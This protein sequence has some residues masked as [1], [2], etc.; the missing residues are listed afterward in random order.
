[1]EEAEAEK[2]L[3]ANLDGAPLAEPNRIR[4]TTGKRKKL[5]NKNCV[6]IGLASGFLE[7][8][9]S[10]SLFMIQSSV[11]RLIRLFPDGAMNPANVK[12]YNRQS[13][14]EYERIRDFIILHYKAT[15]RDDSAFWRYCRTMEIPAT[16]QRKMEL[17]RAN[18]RIF[19]EDDELFSE[20][21]WIQVF[22]GQGVIPD[23]YDPL[24]DLKSKPQ[25]VQYL[26]NIENTVAK[27]VQVMPTHAAF[28]EKFCDSKA[29]AA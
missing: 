13:D 17:F 16:L 19:R 21:S 1:M 15:E 10:T 7:P 26:S 18:G 25:L 14:F 27:C 29:P 5:W 4:F 6:A 12:E 24:V 11:V 8:L 22:L 3:L 23:G 20:E 28:V 2:L 9:E